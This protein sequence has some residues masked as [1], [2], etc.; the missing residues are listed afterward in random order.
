[1]QEFE[2]EILSSLVEG[3][4]KRN[5]D[6]EKDKGNIKIF[7][8]WYDSENQCPSGYTGEREDFPIIVVAWENH[9]GCARTG[10]GFGWARDCMPLKAVFDF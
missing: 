4:L 10:G 1:M 8:D 2:R 7:L 3:F 5:P 9:W 6:A